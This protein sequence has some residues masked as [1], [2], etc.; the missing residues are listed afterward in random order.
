MQLPVITGKYDKG[1]EASG[2]G[3]AVVDTLPGT[4]ADSQAVGAPM[5]GQRLLADQLAAVMISCW[6][7][8]LKQPRYFKNSKVTSMVTEAWACAREG[9]EGVAEIPS[10]RIGEGAY[11]AHLGLVHF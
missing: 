8:L 10:A 7:L 1:V 2:D 3:A 11:I 9:K 4:P 6:L 5:R